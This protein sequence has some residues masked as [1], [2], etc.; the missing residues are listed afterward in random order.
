[1]LKESYLGA[2]SN[3]ED[4]VLCHICQSPF[5]EYLSCGHPICR[6]CFKKMLESNYYKM[7]CLVCNE[8]IPEYVKKGM[9]PNFSPKLDIDLNI[10]QCPKC[11]NKMEFQEG[12][13]DFNIKDSNNK[14]ISKECAIEYAKY[15]C[16]C[17]CGIDFCVNCQ[18]KN[19]LNIP[20]VPYHLGYTCQKWK[21]KQTSQKCVYCD[22]VINIQNRG[23]YSYCCNNKECLERYKISCK[24]KLKC[25]HR[26]LGVDGE[27]RCLPC[28]DPKCNQYVNFY[29]TKKDDYCNICWSESLEAAPCVQLACKHFVHY[30]CIKQQLLSKWI[31]PNITFNHIRCYCKKII[32]IDNVPEL[33]GILNEQI[34]L[35]NSIRDMAM[36]RLKF[37]GLDKDKRLTDPNSTWYG[38]NEEFAMK[39]LVYYMCFKCKKPYFAGRRECGNDPGM[40]NNDPKKKFDPKDCVC[41]KCANLSGIAGVTNCPRHGKDFIEYKCRFCCR[42]ASWFCW[43][44]THFCDPCHERQQKGDYLTKVPKNKLPKCNKATCE[45]GGKHPPNGEEYAM[46]CSICRNFEENKKD[47]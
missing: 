27:T 11:N 44:T 39:R 6:E 43:G 33:C 19:M 8:L 30:H 14:K 20:F 23:P 29:D 38:K 10:V 13:I 47:F 35:Y 40:D 45:V 28:I 37:E 34:T 12:K 9:F 41:G 46:G 42:M 25:G 7:S 2:N 15:R 26:C 24:K 4:L 22:K 36:K 18:K 16:K 3:S 1:M 5:I 17:L 32:G 21:E 31:G